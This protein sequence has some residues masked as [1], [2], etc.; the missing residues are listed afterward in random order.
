MSDRKKTIGELLEENP[1]GTTVDEVLAPER[2][3]LEETIERNQALEDEFQFLESAAAEEEQIR[4]NQEL[5]RATQPYMGA[6]NLDVFPVPRVYPDIV[7]PERATA[8]APEPAPPV[9]QC[10]GSGGTAAC[11]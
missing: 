11:A 1:A 8:P 4:R 3:D 10:C 6:M 7:V 9:W 5:A 2:S